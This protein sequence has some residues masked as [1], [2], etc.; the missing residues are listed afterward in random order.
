MAQDDLWDDDYRERPRPKRDERHADDRYADDDDDDYYDEPFRHPGAGRSGAVTFLGVVNVVLGSLLALISCLFLFCGV[1]FAA[2][3]GPG[4]GFGPGD[5]L[6]AFIGGGVFITLY[7]IGLIMA[8]IGVL[9][10]RNW[11]RVLNLV[12]GG[13][14]GVA[15]LLFLYRFIQDVGVPGVSDEIIGD[16][17][18]FALLSGYVILAYAILLNSHYAT[19][20]R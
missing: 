2:A 17:F 13:F 3:A 11:G 9:N 12:L 10:R 14:A 7:S 15:A 20:F 18:V 4:P 19:E 5:G 16:L 1:I 8:G 6:F